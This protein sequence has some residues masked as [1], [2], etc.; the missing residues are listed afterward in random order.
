MVLPIETVR[1]R[2][3]QLLDETQGATRSFLS[4]L[5]PDLV[6]HQDD[7]AWRV[8]D[9]LGHLG[10][11]NGEAATSLQAY[12]EDR[13]YYCVPAESQYDSYNGPA[14]DARR[15][16]T[17]EQVWA[18]YEASHE[19]LRALVERLPAAKW[20]GEMLYPWNE[21]G[22]VE[23]LIQIMMTHETRDHCAVIRKA[24]G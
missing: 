22:T 23:R 2:T 1:R 15:R 5:D 12:S 9:V 17:L 6:V 20:E 19:R 10:V 18:E 11:W 16:W 13:E 24:P 14:A 4:S 21:R 8:R 3:L 7:R